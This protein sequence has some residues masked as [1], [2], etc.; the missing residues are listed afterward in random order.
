MRCPNQLQQSFQPVPP[1]T[2]QPHVSGLAAYAELPT[3]LRHG[4][5]IAFI[6]K[7]KPPPLSIAL[8]ALQGIMTFYSPLPLAAV[9]AMSPVQSVRHVPVRTLLKTKLVP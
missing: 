8:F 4:L 7:H 1:I 3:K 5:L 6:R 2:P 9:S